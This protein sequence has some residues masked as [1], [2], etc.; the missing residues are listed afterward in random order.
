M[1]ST[2]RTERA[3]AESGG[4]GLWRLVRQSGLGPAGFVI[5]GALAELAGPW[6]LVQAIDLGIAMAIVSS[7]KNRPIDNG[8]IVMGEVGLSGEVR[9]VS[10]IPARVQEAKKL[11]FTSCIIPYVCLDSVKDIS[12][13]RIIGVRHVGEAMDLI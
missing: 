7:F 8:M 5:L 10:M 6:C 2:S 12:G 13:I 3:V 1:G 4:G 11:G 9:A